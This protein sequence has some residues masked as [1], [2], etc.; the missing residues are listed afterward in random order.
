M[1]AMNASA[2]PTRALLRITC[3]SALTAF[4]ATLTYLGWFAWD[5]PLVPRD[6]DSPPLYE[7]WQAIGATITL[8]VLA[9]AVAWF[10]LGWIAVVVIPAV[11]TLAYSVDAYPDAVFFWPLEA[12]LIGLGALL[13]VVFAYAANREFY[14]A[15]HREADRRAD[16]RAVHA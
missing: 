1:S 13:W 2:N 7:P 16:I 12:A 15:R 11:F 4:L 9:A 5:Q 6:I 14:K 8:A 3:A 10:S